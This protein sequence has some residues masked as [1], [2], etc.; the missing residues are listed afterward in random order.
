M[1]KS[2]VAS[3]E[4]TVRVHHTLSLVSEVLLMNW[5]LQSDQ[6]LGCFLLFLLQCLFEVRKDR[7]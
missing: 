3:E 7:H 4:L 5:I 6:W 2:V 1:L